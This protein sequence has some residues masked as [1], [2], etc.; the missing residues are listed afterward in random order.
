RAAYDRGGEICDRPARGADGG[1]AGR[2]RTK[3]QGLF[4]QRGLSG[5]KTC[6]HRKAGS[7]L[8]GAL[9]IMG[10]PSA[11]LTGEWQSYAPLN[12]FMAQ[13]GPTWRR[14][15]DGRIEHAFDASE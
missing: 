13:L 11:P 14:L 1:G 3:A 12:S 9:S 10:N 5:G 7:G 6:I 4:R 8:Q 15:R 2:G